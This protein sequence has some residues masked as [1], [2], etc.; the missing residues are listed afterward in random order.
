MGKNRMQSPE[1]TASF[2]DPRSVV[3]ITRNQRLGGVTTKLAKRNRH[4]RVLSG[5]R[6][7]RGVPVP[8]EKSGR[9]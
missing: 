8:S 9:A 6:M 4:Q 3:G 7:L 1:L 2:E 5:G